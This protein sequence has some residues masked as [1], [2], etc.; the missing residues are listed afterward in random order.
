[1]IAIEDKPSDIFEFKEKIC[2]SLDEKYGLL[3]YGK[4]KMI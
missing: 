2:E 3:N 4:F 1:L